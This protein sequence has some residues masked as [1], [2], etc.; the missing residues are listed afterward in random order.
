MTYLRSYLNNMLKK[1]HGEKFK[2]IRFLA[3]YVEDDEPPIPDPDEEEQTGAQKIFY[4]MVNIILMM[5]DG[6]MSRDHIKRGA[7]SQI[8]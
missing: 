1:P 2:E 3:G 4:S 5:L 8:H 6:G 7:P